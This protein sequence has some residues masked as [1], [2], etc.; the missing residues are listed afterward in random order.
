MARP[1]SIPNLRVTSRRTF[2]RGAGGIAI[3]LPWLESIATRRA[4]A[5]GTAGNAGYLQFIHP[6]GTLVDR[7]APAAGNALVLSQMLQPLAG[8]EPELVVVSGVANT[9]SGLNQMSNG[10]NSAGRTLLTCMPFAD[11]LSNGALLPADQQVDNGPAG[12][13]SIDQVLADRI[14]TSTPYRSV[15]FGVGGAEVGEYQMQWAGANDPVTLEGDPLL[16][17]DRL[18]S[19]LDPEM[20]T[21]MTRLRAARKSVLDTVDGAFGQLTVR[22]SAADRLRLEA[23][24]EKIREL[25]DRLD[26][27]GGGGASC[28]VPVLEVPPDFAAWDPALDDQAAKA[29]IDMMVMSFACDLTRVGTL[30]FTDYH[31]PHF[32]WLGL[33]IPG[34]YDSWHTMIHEVPNGG[35]P[36]P[37]QGAMDWYML[38]L[39]YLIT[40]LANTIDG[41]DGT[42]RLLDRMLVVSLSEFGNGGTHSTQ[43]LPVVLAGQVG[44]ALATGRH[45]AAE[46]AT[47]GELFAGILGLFGFEDQ[48][49]GWAEECSG[50]LGL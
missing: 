8:L 1:A 13:P 27:L 45:V 36:A 4:H 6:Q 9:T 15:D 12:G 28:G 25:E 23:H 37:V 16:A 14:G 40:S 39:A 32:P 17:F 26:N 22:V 33:P 43:Q 20:P 41:P 42:G 49:F 31:D 5:G 47:S 21:T 44:G 18:F 19:D 48:C 11:N 2:L 46:G 29:F 30:Q 35:D 38:Q 10:H 7:W 50:P 3:A 24:A 34:T